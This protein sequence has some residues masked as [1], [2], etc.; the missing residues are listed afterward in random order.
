MQILFKNVTILDGTGAPG[1]VGDAGVRDGKLVLTDLPDSAERIIDGTGKVLAPGFI[2]AHSHGDKVLGAGEFADLCKVNQGVTTHVTGQC[3]NSSAPFAACEAKDSF[4]TLDDAE[5]RSWT[6]WSVYAE[7]LRKLPKVINVRPFIGFN[8]IRKA[9][10]G[11]DNRRPTDEELSKMQDLLRDAM[12]HGAAG[13]SSGIPYVP[14]TYCDTEE[15]VAMAQVMAPYGGIYTSHIRNESFAL[16]D[17]IE[18]AIEIGRRAGVKVNIS[19]FK[20]QGRSNW[21]SH[22]KAIEVIERARAEG[23]D[24]TCD[25]YPYNCSMTS[26]APCIPPWHFSEGT[27]RLVER[28]KDPQ[29]R[30]QVR[31]E[32][33]DPATNFE[34]LYLNSGGWDGITICTS[35]N[36]PEAEG[37]TFAAYAEKVGKDPFEVYF[38]LI[39]ANEAIG[40]AVYHTISDDDMF[41][42]IRLPYVMVGSDGIVTSRDGMCHPRGWGTMVRAICHFV[43][44][45]AVLPLETVIH[46]M[47]GLPAQRYGLQNKGLIREDYDADLVLF[48]YVNLKDNATYAAPTRLADGIELV[49]VNG[50]PVYENGRLTGATPGQ[51]L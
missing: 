19:H 16:L 14:A 44:D 46:K 3:G 29:F 43:K 9:V 42:I 41:D 32:I 24:V 45:N 26:Y 10:M 30:Q 2:D 13:M 6:T 48:D 25:Q 49:L 37:M 15:L 35:P 47:T 31:Q 38:D 17:A 50:V 28:L 27:E 12:E 34:N 5:Q 22:L 36:V 8:A 21:G 23:I 7:Y 18:E 1:Y 4:S 51:L 20:A 40:S 11:F 39:V 33:E